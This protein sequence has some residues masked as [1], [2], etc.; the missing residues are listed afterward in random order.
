MKKVL[1]IAAACAVGV[2]V[3]CVN[4]SSLA[5]AIKN[6]IYATILVWIVV[7]LIGGLIYSAKADKEVAA[8]E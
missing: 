8:Q 3:A 4:S 1:W 2:A 6:S 5:E 7:I